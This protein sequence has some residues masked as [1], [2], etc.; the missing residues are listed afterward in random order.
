[1]SNDYQYDGDEATVMYALYRYMKSG[2]CLEG[3]LPSVPVVQH[4]RPFDQ[5]SFAC[6]ESHAFFM[7]Q[8]L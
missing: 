1:M 5:D 8:V 7:F 4:A 2:S 3:T 6:S